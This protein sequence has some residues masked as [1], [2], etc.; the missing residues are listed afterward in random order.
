MMS[1]QNQRGIVIALVV[2][3]ASAMVLSL[4]VIPIF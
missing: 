4:A 2:L 1:P 3:I